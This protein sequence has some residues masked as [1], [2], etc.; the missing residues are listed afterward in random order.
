[1]LLERIVG[2]EHPKCKTIISQKLST[3]YRAHRNSFNLKCN[4]KIIQD[5]TSNYK[6][7]TTYFE[8]Q[9]YFELKKIEKLV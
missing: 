7:K 9:T 1:M 6:Q 5:K 2:M 4:Y 3:G 8:T